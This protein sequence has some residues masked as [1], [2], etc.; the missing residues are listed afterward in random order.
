M[1]AFAAPMNVLFLWKLEY[2]RLKIKVEVISLKNCK[3]VFKNGKTTKKDFTRKW[4]EL[5]NQIE[6]RKSTGLLR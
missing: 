4:I 3:S 6:K 2:I 5:I 1:G